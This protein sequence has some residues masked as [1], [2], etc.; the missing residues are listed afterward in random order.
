M[1]FK[2]GHQKTGGRKTGTSNKMAK[3]LREQLRDIV[4]TS[5]DDLPKTLATMEPTDRARYLVALLPYV[6]P[7]LNNIELR[8]EQHQDQLKKNFPEWLSPPLG[9][10]IPN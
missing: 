6:I 4:Q 7:K 5:L 8:T 10:S 1:Q 3:E 9:Q 2:K